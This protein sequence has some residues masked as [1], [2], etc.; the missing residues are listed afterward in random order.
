M[1]RC[2][3]TG[4]TTSNVLPLGQAAVPVL[5]EDDPSACVKGPKQP[6]VSVG[7][8]ESGLIAHGQYIYQAE[9]V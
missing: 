8:E 2:N 9:Y 3:V 4:A 6:M 1:F 5:C 7:G